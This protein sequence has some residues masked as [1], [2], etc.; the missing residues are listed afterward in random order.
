MLFLHFVL[1]VFFVF[2]VS[3]LFF[4]LLLSVRRICLTFW[5]FGFG[6]EFFVNVFFF[7]F[8]GQKLLDIS[9]LG[10]FLDFSNLLYLFGGTGFGV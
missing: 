6:C 7:F 3:C 1:F 2:I 5:G 8:G 4:V 9:G 10:C